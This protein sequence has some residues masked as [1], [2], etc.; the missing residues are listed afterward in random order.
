MNRLYWQRL[1]EVIA[2]FAKMGT[3]SFGGPAAHIA[4]MERELVQQKKWLDRQ[5]FLDLLA[6]SQLIPG[7]NSTE[8]A[9]HIGYRRAGWFGLL[10]AG[11]SFILPAMLLVAALAFVYEKYALLPMMQHVMY[12]IKPVIVAVI[13]HALWLLAKTAVKNRSLAILALAAF[14]ALWFGVHELLVLP[15]VAL[16]YW[17]QQTVGDASARL[18]SSG[19][20][21]LPLTV[22][23]SSTVAPAKIQDPFSM[24][25]M[26]WVFLKIG[27]VLYG[28]GYVLLAYLQADFVERYGA[29]SAQQ[30]LD[31][32]TIGQFTP[33]PLFTTA[34]FV[35]YLL[36]GFPGAWLATV[37]IFLPAFIFVALLSPW[38]ANMRANRHVSLALDGINVAS[39]AF[40]GVV[41]V[42]LGR[43][44][45]LDP[46]SVGLTC[47]A[48]FVLLRYQWNSAWLVL[49]GAVCGVGIGW[50]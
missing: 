27:A 28:S 25:Q 15:A 1:L 14:A 47:A 24:S 45:L 39:L 43:D 36:H 19:W 5:T 9:I 3:I 37:A 49:A 13:L 20:A 6:V 48:L 4:L 21:L 41:T 26:F 40:M 31:A 17:L 8:L 7:P 30:L 29:L 38:T 42:V 23:A 22:W 32:V 2:V 18:R 46:L 44:V 50:F 10:A 11:V 35:G 16:L 34:T 33:G 12:G